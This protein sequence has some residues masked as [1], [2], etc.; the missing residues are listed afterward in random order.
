[1]YIH[2]LTEEKNVNKSTPHRSRESKSCP[3][4]GVQFC[5]FILTQYGTALRKQSSVA[6]SPNQAEKRAESGILEQCLNWLSCLAHCV[7]LSF[8]FAHKN[9]S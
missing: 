2:W 9:K 8:S 7:T 5:L 6:I 4:Y 3:C 1:M